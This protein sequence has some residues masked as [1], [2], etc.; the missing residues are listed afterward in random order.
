MS[1][2]FWRVLGHSERIW[3]LLGPSGYIWDGPRRELARSCLTSFFARPASKSVAFY[4]V[5]NSPRI[6]PRILRG[7]S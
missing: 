5:W 3:G 4:I 1:G 2:A 6:P 7:V